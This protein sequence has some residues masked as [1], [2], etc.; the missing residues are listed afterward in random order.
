MEFRKIGIPPELFFC[1]DVIMDTLE[2]SIPTMCV[3]DI[4][5]TLPGPEFYIKKEKFAKSG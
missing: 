4:V 3:G 5:C 1:L 2:G